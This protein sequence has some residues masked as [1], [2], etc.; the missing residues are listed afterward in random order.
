[1]LGW[2]N[3]GGWSRAGLVVSQ[4]LHAGLNVR[5]LEFG[6]LRFAL[7]CS[8]FGVWGLG[9]APDPGALQNSGAW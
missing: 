1:L 3:Q 2:N 9:L 4:L 7:G 6:V 5:R 8:G